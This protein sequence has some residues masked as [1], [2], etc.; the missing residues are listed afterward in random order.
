MLDK[1]EV[2]FA[3]LKY[4]FRIMTPNEPLYKEY[5]KRAKTL[6]YDEADWIDEDEDL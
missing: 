6:D 5:D 1:Q 3:L 4:D 2:V